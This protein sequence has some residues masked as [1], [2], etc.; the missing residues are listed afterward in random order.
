MRVRTKES[1]KVEMTKCQLTAPDSKAK[2]TH[3][4]SMYNNNQNEEKENH[5]RRQQ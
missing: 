2:E 1:S 4:Q 3:T 5:D